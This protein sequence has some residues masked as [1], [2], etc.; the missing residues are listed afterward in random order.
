[1]KRVLLLSPLSFSLCISATSQVRFSTDERFAFDIPEKE[2]NCMQYFNYSET[3]MTPGNAFILAKMSEMI[4]PERL[5]YQTRYLQNG[6]RPVTSISSTDWIEQNSTV[7]NSNIEAV[8]AG[9]FA[10]YFFDEQK[11]PKRLALLA[12]PVKMVAGTQQVT[13]LP[14]NINLRLD[15]SKIA[16]PQK[17]SKPVGRNFEED[18]IAWV[19]ENT[20][21]F[22]FIR[23]R[24]G[25]KILGIDAG[26][27][28]ELM[29]IDAPKANFIVFR[30]TD[31]YKQ[32]G[33][34]GEWIGTDFLATFKDGTGAL[35]GTKIHSGFYES[36][37][38]IR[39]ELIA[40]LNANGGKSKKI[41]LTGH[42]LGSAMAVIAGVDL[43]AAGY[44]V[45]SIYGFSA[46]RVLGNDAFK[47]KG[48]S[49]LP[50]RIHR[51]EYYLDPVS[52]VGVPFY[53]APGKR[54]WFDHVEYGDLQKYTTDEDRYLSAN[55]CEFN[56]CLGDNRSDNTVRILKA[57]KSGMMTDFFAEPTQ[58]MGH[59]H[60]PQWML[61]GIYKLLSATEKARLPSID[62]SFPFLYAKGPTDSPIP[63]TR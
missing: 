7:N 59:N 20:A 49:L 8:F 52:V 44:N 12:A 22:K 21:Q 34:R 16:A 53:H 27:D 33:N 23:Q 35:S 58:I 31:A 37:L 45:Q 47:N 50:N 13:K 25:V 1:M 5:Y 61:R 54:H 63:G 17:V 9:R 19:T 3:G 40:F 30:G 46:P 10:H 39:P 26:F 14:T 60:N 32:I 29:M 15:S 57:R 51:F 36:Y 43:K 6:Q 18:S 2:K 24:N 38:L 11:R 42:S 4:Y 62:D 48:N 41:W 55:P 28:P 56:K